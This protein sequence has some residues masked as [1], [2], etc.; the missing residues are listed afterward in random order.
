MLLLLM[1]VGV[2]S[3]WAEEADYTLTPSAGT[4]NSYASN[5]DVTIEGIT[6]NITG[7]AQQ[8]PWR[9]GGKSI[10][11]TDRVVYS[12]TAYTSAV[13]KIDLTVGAASSITVNSLKLV[14]SNNADFSNSSEISKTFSANSTIS[15][16]ADF[17]ANAY[18]K[19]VFNVTVSGSNN[20]YVEFSKVEFFNATGGG[21][22]PA[23]AYTVTFNAGSN[24]SCS[25][26]SLTEASAGAGVTLP[27]VTANTGYVFKGWATTSGATTANA[28]VSGANYKPSSDCILYAVY[29]N[30]YTVTLGDNFTEL[31]QETEDGDV[32]L[33]TR[34]GNSTYTFAGWSTTN[35]TEETTTAPTII[36]AGNYKPTENV[37]L[38]PVY[39][40]V[41][42]E[43]GY[44]LSETVSGTTYYMK[45][46]CSGTI[47]KAEA[48]TFSW[49]ASTGLLTYASGSGTYYITHQTSG[50]T[51]LVN[52]TTVPASGKEWTITDN[53]TN[54][55]VK[56]NSKAQTNRYLGT[57]GSGFKAYAASHTLKYESAGTAY[58]ISSLPASK[59]LQSIAVTGTPADFWKGDEFNHNG[60]TV[61]AT[62][63]DKSETDVTSSCEFSG[64]NMSAAGLQTVTVTYQ[65]ET[66]TYGINVKTIANTQ[67]TAYTVAEAKALIDAGKDLA[68]EVYVKGTI[69]QV[70]SYNGNYGSIT[71]WI[72]E[73]GTTTNQFEVYGG[74]ALGSEAKFTAKENLTVGDEVIVYG[75][76]Q[77]YKETYEFNLNSYL[78]KWDKLATLSIADITVAYGDDITPVITTN[79][80]DSYT[81][82]Y[83]SDNKDVVLADGDELVTKGVGT[84]TITATLT[85][86]GYKTAETTFFVTVTTQ[87]TLSS[88]T[89]SGE[90]T[91]K[92]YT[93][94][95]AFDHTGL[96]ATAN[97][98]DD[99]HDDV[100]ETATWE[101]DPETLTTAGSVIVTVS[102]SFG[103]QEDI[104]EYEVSV[105]KKTASISFD[106]A[107]IEVEVNKTAEISAITT[108]EDAELSYTITEGSEFISL[109]DG[110]ITGVAEGTA[111]VRADFEGNDEYAATSASLTVKVIPEVTKVV[112]DLSTDQTTTATETEMSWVDDVVR[113][114][115]Y[116]NG[117]STKTN[118]YY[119][120][121]SGQSYTST[122]FYNNSILSI[123]PANGIT[124]SSIIFKT[125]TEGYANSLCRSEWLN[126]EASQNTQTVTVSPTAGSKSVSVTFGNTVGVTEITII[127]TGQVVPPTPELSSITLSGTYPTEFNVGDEF[128]HGGM[129]VTAHYTDGSEKDVTDDATFSG[130]DSSSAGSKTITVSYTEGDVTKTE[131]YEIRIIS[132]VTYSVTFSIR[133]NENAITEETFGAG[134]SVP[135]VP[136]ISNYEFVGWSSTN[137][138][139]ETTTRPEFVAVAEGRYYPTE[140]ITLYAIFKRSVGET[141]N[142]EGEF[143]IYAD[144]NGTKYY[145]AG[146]PVING[147]SVVNTINSTTEK[148]NAYH[149]NISKKIENEVTMYSIS[150]VDGENVKYLWVNKTGTGNSANYCLQSTDTEYGFTF[151]VGAKDGTT[152][153]LSS[154]DGRAIAFRAGNYNYFRV[155]STTNLKEESTEYYDPILEQISG[156][157]V[158]YY[159]TLLNC[160][161][162]R[163]NSNCNLA[164][165]CLPYNAVIANEE[166][167]K[168]T[169]WALTSISNG[170]LVLKKVDVL[171]ANKG[172]ILSGDNSKTIKL[173]ASSQE[174]D[175]ETNLMDG[176]VEHTVARGALSSGSDEYDYPWILSSDGSFKRYTGEYLPANKGYLDGK[177]VQEIANSSASA[178]IRLVFEDL[179]DETGLEDVTTDVMNTEDTI[180]SLQGI[181]VISVNKSGLYVVN[182]K[183]KWLNAK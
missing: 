12:K 145:M 156:A 143:I 152:R 142:D 60:I 161:E 29:G 47:T 34:E 106:P 180:Y 42:G 132:N 44:I 32:T 15:F 108:P 174:P 159:T 168:I 150:Y 6:W 93:I 52:N 38:Y 139:V 31:A 49:N 178:A 110:N 7:N 14:Y 115:V 39:K 148:A 146:K 124:I 141:T 85:A 69:S 73:D 46:D 125:T 147:G 173:V 95:D 126:A 137:A 26:S 104:Q 181:R 17:P 65:G 84:A 136:E 88:V 78:V 76:I 99:T 113:V 53:T 177:Y 134:V 22:T 172:Y 101:V 71:Y 70:D 86:D 171:V 91:N 98:S 118:N 27:D 83:T 63:D 117:A 121:T 154:Y 62:W 166:E 9:L 153:I 129:T 138:I 77:K 179:T 66:T 160:F 21:A 183:T 11:N 151:D 50:S 40:R 133:G 127:Y 75:K 144:V 90:L 131:E 19:F 30:L 55:T 116:K 72:S 170:T 79:V 149:Y 5:C 135:N 169:A 45:H 64:Y 92:T 122:R 97:Y 25:T 89:L 16:E 35:N 59:T 128:R 18:Y 162:L 24:G 37:T 140:D 41:E 58:Y 176:V 100:T 158:T 112:L 68:S 2:S 67:A 8:V 123:N 81:I 13:S 20:K 10:T 167:D 80:T 87:A 36:A 119:P 3:V 120:G 163:T 56:F 114:M 165:V 102:A 33:P 107:T 164:T 23:T 51:N 103:G 57:T 157:G 1:M 109:E 28:G 94:G 155:Y 130:F 96:V 4:N 175:D 105:N 48:E 74:L 182:G 82:E 111:T 54:K 61:T 43:E